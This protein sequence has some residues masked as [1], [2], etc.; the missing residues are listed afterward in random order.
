LQEIF[1][2]TRRFAIALSTLWDALRTVSTDAAFDT[3]SST[4]SIVRCAPRRAGNVVRDLTLRDVLLFHRRSKRGRVVVD[5]V[6]ARSDVADGG[7]RS[8]GRIL[9]GRDVAPL[10]SSVALAVC[11]ANDLQYR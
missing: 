9:H 10:M 6:H 4:R 8:R 3:S 7:D 1:D 2:S 5:L 11:T